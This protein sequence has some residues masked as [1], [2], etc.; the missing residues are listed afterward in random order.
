MD[1]FID[2]YGEENNPTNSSSNHDLVGLRTMHMLE[3]DE[4]HILATCL[5]NYKGYRIIC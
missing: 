1:S 5:V 3:E 4:I 2:T